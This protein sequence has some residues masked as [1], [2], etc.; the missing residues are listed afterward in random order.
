MCTAD[1][2][3]NSAMPPA[4]TLHLSLLHN[5]DAQTLCVHMCNC[6]II[7]ACA[8]AALQADHSNN[9][10]HTTTLVCI[11]KYPPTA[12]GGHTY[13]AGC[14][15]TNST[16]TAQQSQRFA[17]TAPTA[18]IH[19][20]GKYIPSTVPC[21]RQHHPFMLHLALHNSID[22]CLA[23]NAL[24]SVCRIPLYTLLH[25]PARTKQIATGGAAVHCSTYA[26]AAHHHC[27]T[28]P[29]MQSHPR[30]WGWK[31]SAASASL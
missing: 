1:I 29:V 26:M 15:I 2:S 22:K 31:A 23:Q 19:S 5:C 27:H 7:A 4:G 20:E 25:I 16:H 11:L 21:N 24:H 28:A 10:L 13:F 9:S 8:T 30:C 18:S 17:A 12:D 3:L 6:R 14:N